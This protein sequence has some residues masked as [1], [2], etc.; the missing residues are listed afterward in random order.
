M[1]MNNSILFLIILY[2]WSF[3]LCAQEKKYPMLAPG[4]KLLAIS[5]DDVNMI[6]D[7]IDTQSKIIGNYI[8]PKIIDDYTQ[9]DRELRFKIEDQMTQE[10]IYD[11]IREMALR[12][13]LQSFCGK[14]N[15]PCK[16]LASF[17]YVTLN[18]NYYITKLYC[19]K[20]VKNSP[21][22]FSQEEVYSNNESCVTSENVPC[23]NPSSWFSYL[24]N[25]SGI[26][27]TVSSTVSSYVRPLQKACT[28][29][30]ITRLGKDISCAIIKDVMNTPG[31]DLSL[32]S[33]LKIVF[34][35][36]TKTM[37]T[38]GVV[39]TINAMTGENAST[40]DIPS[41]LENAENHLMIG[42]KNKTLD[43]TQISK[44]E[45]WIRHAR[46]LASRYAG[47]KQSQMNLE[48]II[49]KKSGEGEKDKKIEDKKITTT[50]EFAR[51]LKKAAEGEKPQRSVLEKENIE[52]LNVLDALIGFIQKIPVYSISI[53]ER[54][55]YK[56]IQEN[57]IM[58]SEKLVNALK[59][60]AFTLAN[61]VSK[62]YLEQ[63]KRFPIIT[64]GKSTEENIPIMVA[65]SWANIPSKEIDGVELNNTKDIK[66]DNNA[67]NAYKEQLV[68]A[69]LGFKSVEIGPD[70]QKLLRPVV[71]GVILHKNFHDILNNEKNGILHPKT[72]PLSRTKFTG[73]L[74]N[75]ADANSETINGIDVLL[76]PNYVFPFNLSRIQFAIT[77]TE[78]P[79]ELRMG[80]ANKNVVGSIQSRMLDMTT[81]NPNENERR[82]FIPIF[83]KRI[84]NLV[85]QKYPQELD[86][87]DLNECTL[88]LTEI[89]EKD[90]SIYLKLNKKLGIQGLYHLLNS[91]F[92]HIGK[93]L[94]GE[95]LNP[96]V[97][98]F[99]ALL[100]YNIVAFDL[101]AK[102]GTLAEY[103]KST[104]LAL[105]NPLDSEKKML[106]EYEEFKQ[107]IKDKATNYEYLY[108]MNK[109]GDVKSDVDSEVR[110]KLINDAKQFY[111]K[112]FKRVNLPTTEQIGNLLLEKF[113]YLQSSS[114]NESD[115][116]VD[117]QP[118]KTDEKDVDR[119]DQ[120]VS[121]VQGIYDKIQLLRME[122]KEPQNVVNKI[123]RVNYLHKFAMDPML[124]F[125][126]AQLF[127]GLPVTHFKKLEEYL[128]I[129]NSS[130]ESLL[131]TLDAISGINT[132]SKIVRD[133][134]WNRFSTE[135][136]IKQGYAYN[137]SVVEF[138]EGKVAFYYSVPKD[139][140]DGGGYHKLFLKPS[141]FGALEQLV[142]ESRGKSSVLITRDFMENNMVSIDGDTNK[143]L[144]QKIEEREGIKMVFF[145]NY[146]NANLW[147]P[148]LKE[149][150]V[151]VDISSKDIDMICKWADKHPDKNPA[152]N[153][154]NNTNVVKI[155]CIELFKKYLLQ[156]ITQDKFIYDDKLC[157]D[158]RGLTIF[159]NFIDPLLNAKT[160][161]NDLS[162]T[163]GLPPISGRRQIA[164]SDLNAK[165]LALKNELSNRPFANDQEKAKAIDS[166]TMSQEEHDLFNSLIKFDSKLCNDFQKIN[167]EE[168]VP[169]TPLLHS[170]DL[171]I[172]KIKS[173]NSFFQ[174]ESLGQTAQGSFKSML[175][176]Y[177]V[178]TKYLDEL[179][180][181]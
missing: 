64:G 122:K 61:N 24:P 140:K 108:L 84:Q 88:R 154:L 25:L 132:A 15:K 30:A 101:L 100:D 112:Y 138:P 114:D 38:Q 31:K 119:F 174:I 34:N 33:I 20:N 116:Q 59:G 148:S 163:F 57:P 86:S 137:M 147:K 92:D 16:D 102:I 181:K 120:I 83:I 68:K 63:D 45:E 141:K 146:L 95:H 8:P 41:I 7:I 26:T 62:P 76:A 17:K 47:E 53:D 87:L 49:P 110:L 104:D 168:P 156:G 99:D 128:Q 153:Y 177:E 142:R 161:E 6:E 23:P 149:G 180:G 139:A 89:I 74:K 54:T 60:W 97:C 29:N 22:Q 28:N 3:N 91:Y 85:Q 9:E 82:G 121:L 178:F 135:F 50:K 126:F 167:H 72:F 134:S 32:M 71:N 136:S 66:E 117:G 125:D 162:L 131:T 4:E 77:S 51:K 109:I 19:H 36:A 94:Q 166:L 169:L 176:K 73:L 96:Q 152:I 111:E 155:E 107:F 5:K 11:T 27:A 172:L 42:K 171:L 103:K 98:S 159:L 65:A 13:C 175:E 143:D 35:T 179:K 130:Q 80:P 55:I 10:Q 106:E 44:M 144:I 127:G 48:Q 145:K 151:V 21:K 1:T 81:P 173:R 160:T 165:L 2:F 113:G 150:L 124:F 12:V 37:I 67:W 43:E 115:V 14:K 58:A 70:G 170:I 164:Q 18:D 78:F 46:E 56:N 105:G 129:P 40:L 75:V 133:A 52:L 69:I 93:K 39:K 123:V 118:L 157:F 158:F 79:E 90:I